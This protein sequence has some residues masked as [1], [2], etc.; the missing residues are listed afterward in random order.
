MIS[1]TSLPGRDIAFAPAQAGSTTACRAAAARRP[2][3]TACWLLAAASLIG[4]GLIGTAL[5]TPARADYLTF[6]YSDAAGDRGTG[7]LMTGSSPFDSAGGLWAT[8]GSLDLT[9][10]A[11]G[12]AAVGT[13]SLLSIGPN[14]TSSP[15]GQFSA[16]NL[17]YP[18]DNAAD[19]FNPGSAANNPSFLTGWGLLFGQPGTGSQQEVNIFGN[20]PTLAQPAGDYAFF[21]VAGGNLN[22]QVPTGGVFTLTLVTPEPAT[23]VLAGIAAALAAL[24]WRRRPAAA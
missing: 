7:W 21:T 12:N 19:G 3:R 24:A 9:A 14:V 5:P 22:I 1:A 18:G 4:L 2:R 16:D 20:G 17:V 13:Y 11:N 8:S 6:T 15:S 10:S 23:G